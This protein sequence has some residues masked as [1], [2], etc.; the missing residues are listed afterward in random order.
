[1]SKYLGFY[2]L[3]ISIMSC[4]SPAS[5]FTKIPPGIW[6][7]T[8]LLDRVPVQTYGDDR[9]IVKKFDT[10]S[11]LPFNFEVIYED[12]INFYIVI[13]NG[14]ERIEVRDIQYGTDRSTAKDTIIIDFPI[15]DTQIRAI[16]EDGVMEGDWIVNYRDGYSIPFK[17]IHGVSDRFTSISKNKPAM[18]AGKWA[19]TFEIGTA[20]EYPA[21]GV[22]TQQSDTLWGTFLTET[23]DYRYLE[24]KVIDQ[25]F[26][27]STFDGAH[28]FMFLGK[29]LA[30]GTITGTF[31]SGSQYTTSWEARRT[32][33]SNL[34]SM[35]ELTKPNSSSAL[36][37]QLPD[38]EGNL[39]DI[40]D[41]KYAGKPKIIQIMGTWC[42]NCMD[43]SLFLAEYMKANPDRDVLVFTVGFERYEDKEKSISVLNKFKNRMN[44]THP[45]LYGGYYDKNVASSVFPQ[46]SEIIS[47]PTTI[48][49]DRNNKVYKVHTGFNGPATTEYEAFKK[50]F[51]EIVNQISK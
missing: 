16:Y 5:T 12:E 25:K 51:N 48:F 21:L 40:N 49:L 26:Y 33:K 19:S 38:L 29:I 13:H 3:V 7:G 27:L 50:T 24:G 44:I 37:L 34:K 8:L 10:E 9:D 39:V 11:E 47:Y 23:G 36:T 17:A 2:I 20:D 18:V 1:M 46:L 30:D 15:Y 43:E 35:D 32:D 42:P 22:F 6:R 4:V 31:R 14:K 28:A 45:I 41:I